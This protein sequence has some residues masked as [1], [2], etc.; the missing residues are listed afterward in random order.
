MKA[1]RIPDILVR[2]RV[3]INSL[4]RNNKNRIYVADIKEEM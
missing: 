1:I 3:D 4:G 2:I